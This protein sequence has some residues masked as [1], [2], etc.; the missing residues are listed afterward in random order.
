MSGASKMAIQDNDDPLNMSDPFD[1]HAYFA[2]DFQC[3]RCGKQLDPPSSFPFDTDNYYLDISKRA[4]DSGW[5]CPPANER[6]EMHVDFCLCPVCKIF[7][8]EELAKI[9]PTPNG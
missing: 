8:D 6:D 5:F 1:A 4:K 7:K 2:L 3:D 9:E